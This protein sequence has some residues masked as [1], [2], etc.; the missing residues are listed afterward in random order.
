MKTYLLDGLTVQVK[1]CS[2]CPFFYYIPNYN[3]NE[4]VSCDNFC[5]YPDGADHI[6][7]QTEKHIPTGYIRG[8]CPLSDYQVLHQLYLSIKC[9]YNAI[10]ALID[11]I[12]RNKQ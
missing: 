12:R 10:V 7:W 6:Q 9:L 8:D 4:W 3:V 1:D 11:K 2:S 5:Q